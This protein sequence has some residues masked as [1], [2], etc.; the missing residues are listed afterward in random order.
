M[1]ST[2][3]AKPLIALVDCNNFYAS[4][5]RVFDPLLEGRPV[6]ILSSNDGCVIARSNEAKALGIPMGAPAFEYAHL[7][8]KHGIAVFSSNFALYGD[9][10]N[11]VMCT[12]AQ[13][14]DDLEIYSIDEAFLQLQ[15]PDPV[16]QAQKI[17]RLVNRWT[18]IPVSIGI[19]PTKTLAKAA[20]RFVKKD[21]ALKG[22]AMIGSEADQEHFLSLLPV[23][24]IWGIGSRLS[25]LLKRHGLHTAWDFR[26]ADDVWIR[27]HMSVVGLRTA[28]ELRGIS[29]LSMHELP[30]AKKSIMSSRSFEK[31]ITEEAD[32]AE[33]ISAY[34]A[35][36]TEK[37]RSEER[38][39]SSIQVFL[40]TSP[41]RKDEEFYGNSVQIVL[42]QPTDYLPSLIHY[43]KE[44]LK[45][46][47]RPG[48]N[49][50]KAGILLAGLVS[51][52]SLQP[53]FFVPQG[54]CL[55]KQEAVMRLIEAVNHKHGRRIL[56]FAAEGVERE[57][58][59]LWKTK[60]SR[61]TSRYTTRWDELLTIHL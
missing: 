17:R 23:G 55:E 60:Q 42:P 61:C 58:R 28:W 39:A 47:Y 37:L 20:N 41:F 50:K 12:L 25:D 5:E 44:G 31:P 7:F 59:Q 40:R 32:L 33:A 34:T 16:N 4:C 56:K 22:V 51:S 57:N 6:V 35:R 27:K 30:S 38:L 13:F 8:K 24:D 15:P 54:K 2:A 46:I 49:F 19:A 11:R 45:R 48:L 36:A 52:S 10:S 43:A 26:N 29:C 53:D 1:L 14:T 21:P 9:L 18:G 3:Q